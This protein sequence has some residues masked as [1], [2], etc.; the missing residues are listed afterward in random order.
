[1]DGGEIVVDKKGNIGKVRMALREKGAG[2]RVM[3]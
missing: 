1:M 3:L 2:E